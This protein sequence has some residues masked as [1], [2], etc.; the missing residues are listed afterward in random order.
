MSDDMKLIKRYWELPAVI[1]VG[2]AI[3]TGVSNQF[4]PG[5][6]TSSIF[7]VER[8]YIPIISIQ[9]LLV[10]FYCVGNI[11]L[12]RITPKQL[13]AIL[14]LIFFTLVCPFFSVYPSGFLSYSTTWL[15]A[16][17]AVAIHY[18]MLKGEGGDP[19]SKTVGLIAYIF[20][21]FYII[22]LLI[23]VNSF[24]LEEFTSYTLATNGHTFVSMLMVLFIQFDLVAK[25]QR[26]KF[27]S[28]ETL[29][30]IIYLAGG[31]LS[32]GRVALTIM[33]LVTMAIHWRQAKKVLPAV[34]ICL[35][36]LIF[37]NE[38]IRTTFDALI[39]ADF[40]DPIAW[41]SLISR[42][43]FWDVFWDIFLSYPIAGA[44]GLS[45]NIV[46]YDHNFPYTVYVDPHNEFIF[47]LSGFGVSGFAFIALAVY[48]CR[49]LRGRELLH[50]AALNP[51]LYRAPISAIIWFI[52]LCSL[53]NANSAKQN[54]EMLICMALLFAVAGS[55]GRRD[56]A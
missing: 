38:K 3:P 51:I 36:A 5:T 56:N 54:I 55:M 41:S 23:S 19:F 18:R 39:A 34:L 14:A 13:L 42:L 26:L 49:S 45:A 8:V 1:A 31:V 35:A 53:T 2:L 22:D 52:G 47:I 17:V 24:G 37:F 10:L 20:L 25:V 4:L 48:L 9:T 43:N 29:A 11:G 21:P 46:K 50:S 40:D 16:P 27:V 33:L 30:I 44:G 28:Y 12:V 15:L 6:L 7:D 32:Q